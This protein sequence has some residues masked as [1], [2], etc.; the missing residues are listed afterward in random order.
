M[1]WD[2]PTL[3]TL[4]ARISGDISARLLD[5]GTI[6]TRSVLAA[7]SKVWAGACH[8][9]YAF[10]AWL[11][12]QVFVDTAEVEFLAR[13]AAVW[14]FNPRSRAGSDCDL[15]F[16]LPCKD[17]QGNFRAG[18]AA[19]TSFAAINSC[20]QIYHNK[21]IMLKNRESPITLLYASGSRG[22]S[23]PQLTDPFHHHDGSCRYLHQHCGVLLDSYRISVP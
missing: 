20:L 13:W 9:M 7:L 22:L 5:G 19:R 12:P 6:L 4:H 18:H 15:F 16:S 8:G 17:I 21:I 2:R 14:S 1:S 3:K 23:G 11:F 10:F